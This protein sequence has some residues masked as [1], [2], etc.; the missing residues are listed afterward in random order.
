MHTASIDLRA[1]I[2]SQAW[3]T[4]TDTVYI[5]CQSDHGQIRAQAGALRVLKA[6]RLLWF[7]DRRLQIEEKYEKEI[8][9][10]SSV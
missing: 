4:Y 9:L 2:M 1:R 5:E 10:N 3:Y 8:P 7:N 6:I